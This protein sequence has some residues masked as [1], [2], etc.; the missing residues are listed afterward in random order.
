MKMFKFL[1]ERLKE[2]DQ[3]AQELDLMFLETKV[4]SM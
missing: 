4:I 2:E 1:Q 3:D